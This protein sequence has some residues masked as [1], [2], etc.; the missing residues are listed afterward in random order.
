ML[1]LGPTEAATLAAMIPNP[2]RL[3]PC[4]RPKSVRVRRDRILNWMHMADYLTDDE[5]AAA[6]KDSPRLRKC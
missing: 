3:D 4:E 5:L 6:L 1:P 2:M